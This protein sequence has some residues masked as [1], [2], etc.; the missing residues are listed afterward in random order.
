MNFKS[1]EISKYFTIH[2]VLNAFLIFAII[3]TELTSQYT[4]LVASL[5]TILLT[6]HSI[7]VVSY[8]KYLD[9]YDY[10]LITNHY[11][12]QRKNETTKQVQANLK[13]NKEE[14]KLYELAFLFEKY[15][16]N[17]PKRKFIF[18]LKFK[19]FTEKYSSIVY[20][21]SAIAFGILF[22]YFNLLNENYKE[23]TTNLSYVAL[24]YFI[25][26]SITV[27]TSIK[28]LKFITKNKSV[29]NDFDTLEEVI[30]IKYLKMFNDCFFKDINCSEL[31]KTFKFLLV[32]NTFNSFNIK[33]ISELELKNSMIISVVNPEKT[34]KHTSLAKYNS[35]F[36]EIKDSFK[37]Y[38]N[39]LEDE[40][41]LTYQEVTYLEK[42]I[43]FFNIY[44]NYYAND[45]VV[46]YEKISDD[47]LIYGLREAFEKSK[48][49]NKKVILENEFILNLYRKN[50]LDLIK[51]IVNLINEY[52]VEVVFKV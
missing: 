49:N 8:S 5:I 25:S 20:I 3:T 28:F 33:E 24:I 32:N 44:A 36:P 42:G 30:S 43:E 38:V 35:L 18:N 45:L 14:V 31:E 48:I 22:I 4:I 15:N 16:V 39:Q 26:I 51:T 13:I 7:V 40:L 52:E 41:K 6:F 50:K 23:V 9:I 37:A 34:F 27:L 12:K 47:I 46:P 17:I 19:F 10:F 1:K 21:I 2:F 11:I 29:L